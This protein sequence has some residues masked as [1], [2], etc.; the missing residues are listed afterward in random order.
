[1]RTLKKP[2]EIL[3]IGLAYFNVDVKHMWCSTA[4]LM[5]EFRKFY[6]A[7][8]TVLAEQWNTLLF[9]SIEGAKLTEKEASVTGFC[10]FLMTHHFLWDYLCNAVILGW[11]FKVCETYAS[12]RRLWKWVMKIAAL[13]K[14]KIVWPEQFIVDNNEI[15]IITVDGTDC[16]IWEPKHNNLPKDKRLFSQ[17]KN[18]AAV[19][20]L[21]ALAIFSPHVVF[22]NGP[23]PA[24]Q[25]NDITAFRSHLKD[26]IKK[27]KKVIV[28]SGFP[29]NRQSTTELDML[30]LPR[31]GY[32]SKDFVNFKS[33]ACSQQEQFNS[34][35]KFYD[36]LGGLFCHGSTSTSTPLRLSALLCNM[37]W[38]WVS[39]SLMSFIM[40]GCSSSSRTRTNAK[41]SN[42]S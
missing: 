6:G 15:L 30:V 12:R 32:S 16:A 9:T 3:R 27:G 2:T 42:R 14:R 11:R 20:Y 23:F 37:P 22:I 41:S 1:M 36:C 5:L 28:D 29:P 24:G 33:H 26:K 8:C 19:K 25:F 38:T 21:V 31:Q 18:R 4:L 40:M 39:P 13:K 10:N 35:L 17:K 7:C 34:R